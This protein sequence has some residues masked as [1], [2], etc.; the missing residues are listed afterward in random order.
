MEWR[1]ELG[2]IP[3]LSPTRHWLACFGAHR[4]D[5]SAL[6][7]PDPHYLDRYYSGLFAQLLPF[8]A[9][10]ADRKSLVVLGAGDH[11]ES[12]NL[13]APL[14]DRSMHP[15]RLFKAVVA[16]RKPVIVPTLRPFL[17]EEKQ[18]HQSAALRKTV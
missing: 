16:A 3:V 12:C 15:R 17:L 2:Q 11:G 18:R 4:G 5:P 14:A 13:F 10:W 1:G 8:Q 9:P 6:L 7:Q